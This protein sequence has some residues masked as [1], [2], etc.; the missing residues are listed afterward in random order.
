VKV[1]EIVTRDQPFAAGQSI[2]ADEANVPLNEAHWPDFSA[3][4]RLWRTGYGHWIIR[5]ATRMERHGASHDT[6]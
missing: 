3:N 4:F 1:P 5:R 2:T 6:E